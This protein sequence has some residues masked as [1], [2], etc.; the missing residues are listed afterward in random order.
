M[1][2]SP[3]PASPGTVGGIH[4]GDGVD[5]LEFVPAC[6]WRPWR[7]WVSARTEAVLRDVEEVIA[8]MASGVRAQTLLDIGCWDGRAS[9]RYARACHASRVFGVEIFNDPAE[10]ARGRGVEIIPLDL[11]RGAL[12]MDSESVDLVVCNQVFE[13]IKDIFSLITEIHRVLSPGGSFLFSVP[14]LAS[15]H[16]RL[17]LFAGLQPTSI[18]VMGPHVRGFSFHHTLRFLTLNG[19]FSLRSARGCGFYPLPIRAGRWLARVFPSAS[20]TMVV[21][22]IR[23]DRKADTWLAEVRRRGF[24]TLYGEDERVMRGDSPPQ[25]G[26]G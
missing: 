7:E 19:L 23:E 1:E 8:A 17:L 14:N 2:T 3:D 22:V 4:G 9:M 16:N 15:L 11:E 12:P 26:S 24:Q 13:H 10:Q 20:H 5:W 21:H 6:D 25:T 18:R